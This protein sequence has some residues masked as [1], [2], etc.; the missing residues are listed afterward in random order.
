MTLQNYLDNP[1]YK[2]IVTDEAE[3]KLRAVTIWNQ[4]LPLDELLQLLSQVMME[5]KPFKLIIIDERTT[6]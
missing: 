5:V 4:G 6:E 2:M 1:K 3:G